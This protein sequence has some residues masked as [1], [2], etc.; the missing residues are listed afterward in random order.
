MR[1]TSYPPDL[2][3]DFPFQYGVNRFSPALPVASPRIRFLYVGLTLCYR[4][5]SPVRCLAGSAESLDLPLN[6]RSVDFH[7]INTRALLGAQKEAPAEHNPDR[8]KS[9]RK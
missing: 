8:C 7:H 5:P 6:G 2:R 3:D 4:L 9:S 1:F